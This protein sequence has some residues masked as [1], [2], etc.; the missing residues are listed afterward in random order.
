MQGWRQAFGTE[1]LCQNNGRQSRSSLL[2]CK[3]NRIQIRAAFASQ[4]VNQRTC[5]DRDQLSSRSA[6][7]FNVNLALP[8]HLRT[9]AVAPDDATALSPSRTTSVT[10]RPDACCASSS[11][12]AL[13]TTVIFRWLK[14]IPKRYWLQCWCQ[15]WFNQGEFAFGAADFDEGTY[16]RGPRGQIHHTRS[17]SKAESAASRV[18]K[19]IFSI[20]L[21]A[22]SIRSK[23][24]ACLAA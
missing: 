14:L 20:S 15:D 24:S 9:A 10:P 11:K 2:K 4:V 22:A 17:M 6:L 8:R 13:T 1:N 21:C 7:T 5:I 23:G 18:S 19:G 16:G 12:S 3:I